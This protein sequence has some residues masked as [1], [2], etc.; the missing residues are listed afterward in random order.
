MRDANRVASSEWPP[1]S[2]EVVVD[3]DALDGQDAGEEVGEHFSVGV[4]GATMPPSARRFGIGQRR[5]DLAVRRQRD[6]SSRTNAAG[7][8]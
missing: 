3:A 6:P 5:V 1:M 8:M 7:T 4:R 2:E